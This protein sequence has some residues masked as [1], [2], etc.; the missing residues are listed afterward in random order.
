[1][2]TV[3]VLV[4]VVAAVSGGVRFRP[5][6]GWRATVPWAT[7][8]V[9]ALTVDTSV[10]GELVPAVLHALERD[11]TMLVAGQWW[12]ILTPLLVQD[13]GWAGTAFN[14]VTLLAVGAVAERVHGLRVLLGVYLTAGLLSEVAAYTVLPHQGF[15]GNSVAN[16]GLAGLCLV[17]F[18]WRG[19]RPLR[20]LAVVGLLAG[21]ILLV[22]G[23]LHGVGFTVGALWGVTTHRPR[24][25]VGAGRAG[26]SGASTRAS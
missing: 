4:V 24:A 21:V 19:G 13:G 10:A 1:M 2:G 23:N 9:A 6:G 20:A 25:G 16:L 11:R 3:L 15:A 14:T 7:L 22:T 12:R 5:E 26:E 17:A 8:T 18:A